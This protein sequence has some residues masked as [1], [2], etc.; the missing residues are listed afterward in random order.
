[1]RVLFLSFDSLGDL[2]FR[3][4]LLRSLVES[5]HAVCLAF[6]DPLREL[7]PFLGLRLQAVSTT[8]NP[9][10]APES[11][12]WPAAED[13][14][15]QL[16]RFAPE[17]V[18]S[19]PF[20]RTALD[21]WLLDRF[22]DCPRY[23]FITAAEEAP[24]TFLSHPVPCDEWLPEGEKYRLLHESI[25]GRTLAEEIPVL[26]LPDDPLQ[27][28]EAWLRER[29]LAA[30]RF[31]LACPGGLQNVGIKGWPAHSFVDVAV[32]LRERHGLDVLMTGDGADAD[33]LGRVAGLAAG[34][35]LRLITW[36]GQ[37]G[38]LGLLLGLIRL[39]RFYLGADTGPLHFAAALGKP[40]AAL[41]GGGTW[42]RFLP[43]A[44]RSFVAA[45]K[46]PC[47]GCRWDCWLG[48]A[49]CLSLV[50]PDRLGQ[51][52]DWILSGDADE[53][54]V[55]AAE[56]DDTVLQKLAQA[57]IGQSRRLQGRLREKEAEIR[58]LAAA[59]AERGRL[60]EAAAEENRRLQER[61]ENAY[62]LLQDKEA[63]AGKKGED[64]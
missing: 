49:A 3:Q 36:V 20:N 15:G 54:R 31:A 52:I 6:R 42:P 33:H 34:R 14:L 58:R 16:R 63:A 43:Q 28:A 7:M 57:G 19:A 37:A 44:R 23:G 4:P 39:A 1:L 38:D 45:Q 47:F 41:F 18:V 26:N 9:Y 10:L 40:V 17:I 62:R 30:G 61:C 53:R 56:C 64:R 2:I 50:A 51:G 21:D 12:A 46:L 11:S 35:G 27:T 13:L 22:T 59:A 29:G 25:T 48:E 24:P 60:L 8:A 5:G 55:A 32:R